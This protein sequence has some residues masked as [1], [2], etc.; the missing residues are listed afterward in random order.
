M[1]TTNTG[2]ITRQ[3]AKFDS[4]NL[5]YEVIKA[6]VVAAESAAGAYFSLC[7]FFTFLKTIIHT[8]HTHTHQQKKH[9]KLEKKQKHD[10][11]HILHHRPQQ[12]Q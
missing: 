1:K 3:K 6:A 2:T 11:F 9:K 12:M 7:F 8:H 10:T 4:Q 5:A